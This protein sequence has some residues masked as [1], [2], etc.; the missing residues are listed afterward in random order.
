M[1]AVVRYAHDRVLQDRMIEHL[2]QCR[3]NRVGFYDVMRGVRFLA[4][5]ADHAYEQVMAAGGDTEKLKDFRIPFEGRAMEALGQELTTSGESKRFTLLTGARMPVE[6]LQVASDMLEAMERQ[7]GTLFKVEGTGS[8]SVAILAKF[9]SVYHPLVIKLS[10]TGVFPAQVHNNPLF[11]EAKTLGEW[12]NMRHNEFKGLLPKPGEVLHDGVFFG[13]SRPN[14]DGLVVPFLICEYISADFVDVAGQ[15]RSDW[16][17]HRLLRDELR[18]KVI[19]PLSIGLFWLQNNGRIMLVVRDLKPDNV[20]F[21]EDGTMAVVDLGSSATFS[22]AVKETVLQRMVSIVERQPTQMG[23][24]RRRSSLLQG[25]S[26]HGA[27]VGVTFGDIHDFCR[28][29]GDKGLALIGGTTRGFRKK[30]LAEKERHERLRHNHALP[31]FD[32]NLGCL[33]DSYAFFRTVFH[34]LTRVP[35]Q[36]IEDWIEKADQAIEGGVDGIK[37]MLLGA[38]PGGPNP[39]QPLAF[40]RLADFLYRGQCG[41][42]MMRTVTHVFPTL[43]IL[44]PVQ[45]LGFSSPEG[46]PFPHGPVPSTWPAGFLQSL[47]ASVRDKVQQS[48]IPDLAYM[49]QEKMGGGVKAKQDV[50]G[51]ALLGAYVGR[52]V[53]NNIC[54]TVYDAHEF[55]SRFNVTGQGQLKISNQITDTK[56]TCDAQQDLVHDFEWCRAINNSGPFMNAAA[57]PMLANCIVDRYSAWYDEST[58][59][60]W[61]LVWAKAAGIKKGEY[62]LWHYNYKAGAGELWHFD[63]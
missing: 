25:R 49:I 41:L 39:Q 27:Y 42:D 54:G 56:F 8:Y 63:D 14:E 16:Q 50:A 13:Y 21:R 7:G 24:Q 38:G 11:R 58:G 31:R 10:K 3:T 20:R 22:V 48:N 26:R 51:D 30:N 18:V 33:Q 60:I 15:H 40:E 55:P 23:P 6:L 36:T 12:W 1:N 62:C 19:Q 2:K 52:R 53:R 35:G 45:E 61:M 5:A 34:T 4:Y 44:T 32:A 37:R 43:A 17:E 9:D 59:L 29:V 46:L 57:S 47:S 28:Q